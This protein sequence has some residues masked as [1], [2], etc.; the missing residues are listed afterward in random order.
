MRVFVAGGT[1][2]IGR[3]AVRALVGEGHA[4][5][6]VARTQEKAQALTELGAHALSVSIF[7]RS[8]LASAFE[9]HD[10]VVNLTSAIPPTTQFMARKAWAENDRV[11]TE[12]SAAIVDAAISAGVE[13]VVQESVSMLYPDRGAEWIDEDVPPDVF[14]MARPN[15]AAEANANRF[16]ER[17]RTGIV[18]RFGWF[19]GPGARHSEQFLALARRHICVVMGPSDSYVSSIYMT[20]AGAA[21]AAALHAPAGTYNIVVAATGFEPKSQNITVL[22]G[23]S[24]QLDLRVSTTAVLKESIAI[25]LA[26]SV[27]ALPRGRQTDEEGRIQVDGHPVVA[28]RV[29]GKDHRIVVVVTGGVLVSHDQGHQKAAN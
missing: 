26:P 25:P 24:L 23:Q 17:G 14:P 3:H 8:A 15:L 9:G 10:A 13:R 29:L 6:A 22:V 12:G 27:I 20:D 7:D 21:V 1:G 11:R 4:V 19:Y 28:V 18:L 5:T 2:A 16:S